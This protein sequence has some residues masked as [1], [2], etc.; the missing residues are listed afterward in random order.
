MKR[1]II[2]ALAVSLLFACENEKPVPNTQTST[3]TTTSTAPGAGQTERA[4]FLSP[5]Q[6]LDRGVLSTIPTGRR[7]FRRDPPQVSDVTMEPAGAGGSVKLL[8]R[9]VD[10]DLPRSIRIE[11]EGEAVVLRD[12][13]AGGDERAGD[14]IFTTVTTLPQD[15]INDRAAQARRF[16]AAPSATD[17]VFRARQLVRMPEGGK[18]DRGTRI[19]SPFDFPGTFGLPPTI[20][21]ERSLL[22]RDPKVVGDKTRTGNPCVAGSNANGPWSFASLMREMANQPTTGVAPNVFV[23]KWLNQWL[24]DQPINGPA[25]PKRPNMQTQIIAP[26]LA[27]SGGVNLD[28]AKAP[29]RLLAIVNRID[30]S[31]NAGYGTAPAGELRFVFGVLS[32]CQPTRFAIIL[33]Y[34]VPPMSCVQ[35]RQYAKKWQTLSTMVPGSPAYNAA[36]QAI[37]D[38]IVKHGAGGAKPNGSTLNQLRTNELFIGS[39]WELREFVIDAGTHLLTETTTKQTPIA[40]TNNTITTTNFVKQHLAAILANNYVV[41]L[42]F[43]GATPY[44]SGNA[45]VP[46]DFWTGNPQIANNDARRNFSLGTCNGCHK[47]ETNTQFVHIDPN[48]PIGAPATLSDFLTGANMPIDDPVVTAT[49]RTYHDLQDRKNKLTAL[50]NSPCLIHGLFFQPLHMVH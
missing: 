5:L 29:L 14:G 44:L 41:P 37:T 40:T 23:R 30:L 38:P 46:P 25:V 15:F 27:A 1:F 50:A 17:R 45:P 26:W 43:P 22:V 24:V 6:P 3:A 39:P 9:F 47:R 35:L 7:D 33:E 42:Q 31:D 20:N 18:I 48:S 8:A 2:P 13:G 34:G 16:A 12:D 28:L 19:L 32:N 49:P 4:A 21:S 11:T 36:L 10:K